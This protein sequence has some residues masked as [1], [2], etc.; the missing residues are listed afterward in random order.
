M[1][2]NKTLNKLEYFTVLGN[3][4]SFAQTKLAQDEIA[5]LLPAAS[6][7]EAQELLNQTYQEAQFYDVEDSPDCSIDDC[8]QILLQARVDSTLSMGELLRVMRLLRTARLVQSTLCKQYEKIDT[9]ALQSQAALIYCDRQ[10]EDDID[11]AIISEEEI[12][13]KASDDL[14][15]I[16]KKIK[17]INADIKEKLI[18]Y[19]K[20]G[21]LSKYL[22]DSIVTLRGDRYVIPVKSE[23]KSYVNGIVHDTSGSGSTFFIEPMAIVELNN[24]LREA[25]LAEKDEI[26][27]ILKAFTSRVGK[28]AEYL[29]RTQQIVVSFDVLFSKVKYAVSIKAKRPILNQNGVIDIQNARHPLINPK[30]VV[31][32][33]VKLGKD[34]DVVVVTGPNTGGKTVTLKTVGLLT[35][36]AMAGFFVPCREDSQLSYFDKIFCVIGDEQSIEQSLSTFSSHMVNLKDILNQCDQSTLVLVDEVG[37][38]TE[39]NEGSALALAITEFLRQSGAKC[40]IT[41]HYSQLK[42]YSLTADRVENASMEF[43]PQTFEPTYKLIMGVPGSSNAISIAEKLGM[44]KQ[45]ID[46]AKSSVSDEKIAFEKVLQNAET[47]RRNYE[48]LHLELQEEKRLLDIESQRVKKMNEGLMQERQKLLQGSKDEAKQIV[49]K[50]QEESKRLVDQIKQILNSAELSDK[51]LFEARALAKQLNAIDVSTQSEQDEEYVFTGSNVNFATLKVGDVA[52]SK[53]LNVQVKI[54][55][56]K[57]KDKIIVKAG[58]ISATVTAGDLFVSKVEKQRTERKYNGGSKAKSQVAARSLSNEI[59]LLGQRV[60]EAVANLDAF[61]DAAVLSGLSTVW[62]IHGMGTGRLRAG[63]HQHLKNHPNVAEFRL[64][65]YGEG[66]SGVTVVTLK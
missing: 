5:H 9:T 16:R 40:L 39:P 12:N 26:R 53:K 29:Q 59:N 63:I 44:N 64:G 37:A 19:T 60:D 31:P 18:S 22:Q 35:L 3:L 21:E 15:A 45:V 48:Q 2:T 61:I 43:N 38:G 42:E 20:R 34:F 6:F 62:V 24:Q 17:K 51:K 23:Y 33:S 41:T 65:K 8:S 25:I 13:D 36:M 4:S 14:Y 10:L 7:E 30:K 58:N 52:F 66:E 50:A 11:F 54:A 32:I 55:E 57:N 27:R 1:I 46:L 49:K 56:I 47:I 28:I